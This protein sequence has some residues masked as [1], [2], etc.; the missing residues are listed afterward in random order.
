VGGGWGEVAGALVVFLEVG[1]VGADEAV[2]GVGPS[3]GLGDD[4]S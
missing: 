2:E 1:E 3:A 4:R